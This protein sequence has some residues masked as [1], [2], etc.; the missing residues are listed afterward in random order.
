MYKHFSCAAIKIKL[1]TGS[2]NGGMYAK[3][4]DWSRI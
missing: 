3:F 2:G 1:T 4:H